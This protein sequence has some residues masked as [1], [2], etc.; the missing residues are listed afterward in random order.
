TKD[1]EIL[2]LCDL[3]VFVVLFLF[4]SALRLPPFY[5]MIT[6][7]HGGGMGFLIALSLV[8]IG[9][10]VV[11]W[12]LYFRQ[13][14]RLRAAQLAAGHWQQVFSEWKQTAEI[15]QQSASIWKETSRIWSEAAEN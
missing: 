1:S 4:P 14:R 13:R 5:G 7:K 2:I 12:S 3:C 8:S 11:G 10:A 6:T 9:L 15:W